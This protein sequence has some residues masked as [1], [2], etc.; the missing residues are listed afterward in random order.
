[1]VDVR[2]GSRVTDEANASGAACRSASSIAR[3][4]GQRSALWNASARSV[5]AASAGGTSGATDRRG[6]AR[7]VAA[8]MMSSIG[9]SDA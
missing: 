1:M 2:I 9:V 8:A 6:L 5:T 7:A 3:A 4:F